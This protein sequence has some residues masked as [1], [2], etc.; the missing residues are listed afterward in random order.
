MRPIKAEYDRY[1][2]LVQLYRRHGWRHEIERLP[3]FRI[4]DVATNCILLR[5]DRDLQALALR[6]GEAAAAAEIGA[7]IVPSEAASSRFV[8]PATGLWHSLDLVTGQHV[9]AATH[10]GFLAFW[11]GLGD[12]GLRQ[13]LEAWMQQAPHGRRQRGAGR[14]AFRPQALLARP[15]LSRG[16]LHDCSGPCRD[17]HA[18]LARRIQADTR[19]LIEMAGFFE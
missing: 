1:M 6:L 7:W 11:A 2:T 8:L 4:G 15:D 14:P 12:V 5:A 19:R 3:P 16:Q 17:G 9:P 10:G 18:R 13:R